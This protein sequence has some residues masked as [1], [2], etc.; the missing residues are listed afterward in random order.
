MRLKSIWS[1]LIIS[2]LLTTTVWPQE[3][4]TAHLLDTVR[5]LSSRDFE[6]RQSGSRGGLKAAKFIAEKFRSYG[7]SV[8]LQTFPL[9]YRRIDG[10]RLIV[11]RGQEKYEAV[12]GTDFMPV[13]DSPQVQVSAPVVFVGYGTCEEYEGLDVS[14]K[15]VLF[16][17]G[18]P[19]KGSG[20]CRGNTNYDKLAFA[21]ER[22]AKAA[23][24]VTGPE[25]SY[26]EA[27]TGIGQRVY[28]SY[29]RLPTG[30]NLPALMHISP[31]IADRL[32]VN[33]RNPLPARLDASVSIEIRT[34]S[35]PKAEGANVVALLEGSDISLKEE[36]IVVGA[37]YDSFGIQAGLLFPGANDNASGVA[38][39][40][41]TARLMARMRPKIGILFVAFAGE[42]AGLLGSKYFVEHPPIPPKKVKTMINIDHAGMGDGNIIAG[43]S[44]EGQKLREMMEGL[45]GGTGLKLKIYGPFPG[46]DHEP[47]ATRGI[48]TIALTSPGPF[49]DYHQTTDTAD[50]I[51]EKL[52]RDV[53]ELVLSILRGLAF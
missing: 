48:S 27:M 53:T 2:L 35:D 52:L 45:K 34:V 24:M 3:V 17:R 32:G 49:V 15:V 21:A 10:A 51:D 47:F 44:E 11:R 41:E 14:G 8:H 42:E 20:A 4:S 29:A 26:F 12:P 43:I 40:T 19:K 22:G 9:T 36:F 5:V 50:K 38:V 28:A 39:I 6:G 33:L 1:A 46:S 31:A 16:I 7:L 23:L 37:H 13:I 18:A 30:S 25:P